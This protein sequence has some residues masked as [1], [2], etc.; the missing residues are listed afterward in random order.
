MDKPWQ[1]SRRGSVY[2]TVLGAAL[3]VS[4]LGL[5]LMTLQ[6]IQ[7]RL[8]EQ[9]TDVVKAS[10]S[11]E[12]ALRMGILRIMD[13]PY[14]RS[15]YS[16]GVWEQDVLTNTGTYTLEG[17]DLND[18]DLADAL[19][20]P[21]ELTGIGKLGVAIQKMAV[22]LVPEQ[23]A[24]SCLNVPMHAGE[25]FLIDFGQ[26]RQKG[27]ISTNGSVLAVG[28]SVVTADV[29]AVQMIS[30]QGFNG[31]TATG[32]EPLEMP[33]S[34]VF[35]YY[36]AHGTHLDIGDIAITYG[37]GPNLIGDSGFETGIDGWMGIGEGELEWHDGDAVAG[38]YSLRVTNRDEPSDGLA[39]NVTT[40][41]QSGNTYEFEVW[42]LVESDFGEG[43]QVVLDIQAGSGNERIE[44]GW[45]VIPEDTWIRLAGTF[46][47]AWTGPLSNAYLKI[48]TDSV[49]SNFRIDEVVLCAEDVAS[50]PRTIS[51]QVIT[52]FSNPN[53]GE[54]N[55]QGIYVIDCGGQ[56]V[57]IEQSRIVGTIV[58][59][60]TGPASSIKHAPVNWSSAAENFPALLVHG[61]MSIEMNN[62]GLSE[63]EVRTNFNPVDAFPADP[64]V[65]DDTT[66]T[67]ASA[68]SGL[69]YVSG[70][71]TF[72]NQP[73]VQGAVVAGSIVVNDR[74]DVTY[75]SIH[76]MNP[77]PGFRGPERLRILQHSVT[78][79][80][81]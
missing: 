80:V 76:R 26:L 64:D 53:G 51:R 21:V 52:P 66:D 58:L 22:T 24:L 19:N 63:Y 77:P 48:E 34:T 38:D 30:G 56:D 14:W 33:D 10:W 32:V 69:I 75:R 72:R 13:D 9:S 62:S 2:I 60:N 44:S 29:R 50:A 46:T 4:V 45:T 36:L 42:I 81:D 49:D 68:I 20:E 54:L 73:F 67:Y 41:V 16:D 35:D 5:S 55:P 37:P 11:A 1:S 79:I 27:T 78:K 7:N 17:H 15:A 12:S 28:N 40:L 8:V 59:I 18:G 3:V 6:R 25:N 57:H 47:P 61:N 23:S 70:S 31:N 43:A 39:K 71:L 65:D 74:L